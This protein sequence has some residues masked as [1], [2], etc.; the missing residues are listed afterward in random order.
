M[1][2]HVDVAD[3]SV[4]INYVEQSKLSVHMVISLAFR[5][6]VT[7]SESSNLPTIATR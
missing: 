6:S 2:L 5:R 3:D 4:I 1:V 7:F